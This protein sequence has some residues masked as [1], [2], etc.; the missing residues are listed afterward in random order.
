[1]LNIF[2]RFS[3]EQNSDGSERERELLLCVD[4]GHIEWCPWTGQDLLEI[5]QAPTRALK[6]FHSLLAFS[7]EQKKRITGSPPYGRESIKLEAKMENV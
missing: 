6:R 5:R 2:L 7:R 3:I 4:G 1:M